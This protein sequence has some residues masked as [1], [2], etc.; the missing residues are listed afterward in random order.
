MFPRAERLSSLNQTCEGVG[1]GPR[2]HLEL[3][4]TIR[5]LAQKHSSFVPNPVGG[6]IEPSKIHFFS[7]VSCY[8]LY[9]LPP[10]KIKRLF[11]CHNPLDQQKLA[12]SVV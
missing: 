4:N 11:H 8:E 6:Q 3:C 7:F 10:K 12:V 5:H 9:R 2:R 1:A